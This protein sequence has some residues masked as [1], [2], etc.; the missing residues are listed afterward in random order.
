[1]PPRGR[2]D[3]Q[4]VLRRIPTWSSP[5]PRTVSAQP[6]SDGRAQGRLRTRTT[7]PRYA[8]LV[9]QKSWL[10]SLWRPRVE[11][12]PRSWLHCPICDEALV[13]PWHA[14]TEA[15]GPQ[16]FVVLPVGASPS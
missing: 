12:V 5:P 16:G 9:A 13:G 6:G 2:R 10:R 7:T 14:G 1:P 8:P 15:S 11:H 4:L 3:R